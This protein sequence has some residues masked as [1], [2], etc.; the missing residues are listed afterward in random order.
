LYSYDGDL[1]FRVGMEADELDMVR[2]GEY[3]ALES[4][5]TRYVRWVKGDSYGTVEVDYGSIA[6]ATGRVYE[7]DRVLYGFNDEVHEDLLDRNPN[8]YIQGLEIKGGTFPEPMTLNIYA[9]RDDYIYENDE[10]QLKIASGLKWD[11][12]D[13]AWVGKIT[14]GKSYVISDSKLRSAPYGSGSYDDDDEYVE[15]SSSSSRP[16][17]DYYNPDTGGGSGTVVAVS[18]IVAILAITIVSVVMSTVLSV[19]NIKKQ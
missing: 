14:K 18:A 16:S 10:G 9:D 5:D 19:K 1:S 17:N 12:N 8:A 11:N 2:D 3:I 4:G 13:D 15:D 7:N 6:M